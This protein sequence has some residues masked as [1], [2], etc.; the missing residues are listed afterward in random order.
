MLIH[1]IG[2]VHV[3]LHLRHDTAEIG[4]EPPQDPGFVHFTKDNVGVLTLGQD[5]KE[6]LIGVRVVLQLVIDMF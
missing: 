1:G 6:H 3:I 2:V 4:D 5:F